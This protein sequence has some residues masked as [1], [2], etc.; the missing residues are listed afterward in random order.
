M[1]LKLDS[2]NSSIK[3][4][5]TFL[6]TLFILYPVI[7][8]FIDFNE[9]EFFIFTVGAWGCLNFVYFKQN[10][11][12]LTKTDKL[13]LCLAIY[14]VT[15]Y[16]ILGNSSVFEIL[17]WWRLSFI[18]LFFIFRGLSYKNS[19]TLKNGLILIVILR[20]VVELTI[21]TLQYFNIIDASISTHFPVSG[22]FTTPN[23]LAL[24]L[25]LGLVTLIILRTFFKKNTLVNVLIWLTFIAG[26]ILFF[27]S[28]SR[29]AY[30][31]LIAVVSILF[32]YKTNSVLKFKLLSKHLRIGLF[33]TLGFLVSITCYFLYN[34]KKDSADGRLF[35]AKITLT[36]IIKKPIFGYGSFTFEEGYNSAKSI[37]FTKQKRG[38]SEIKIADHISH[39]MNDYIEVIYEIGVLGLTLSILIFWSIFRF[40][41]YKN[42]FQLYAILIFIYLSIAALFTTL[43]VN[44]F[45]VL[46]LIACMFLYENKVLDITNDKKL[47]SAKLKNL[48]V[49]SS[50]VLLTLG[51]MKIYAFHWEKKHRDKEK[52]SE[53]NSNDWKFWTAIMAHNG[54]HELTCGIILHK[55]FNNKNEAM[56]IMEKGV[57]KN[58][59][60]NNIRILALYY[61]H[62]GKLN[63]AEKLLKFNIGNEPF[64]FEPRQDLAI[65]YQKLGKKKEYVALLNEIIELPEKVPSIKTKKIKKDAKHRLNVFLK[66]N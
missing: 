64:L 48:F 47:K 5:F 21:G 44:S 3:V 2:V 11:G 41:D 20:F 55:N 15:H 66:N 45:F 57:M 24:C 29:S 4:A 32:I 59:K 16:T 22:T 63:R 37:Y 13:L 10:I 52:Y 50:F 35:S 34:L 31:A 17:F 46:S 53:T 12:V 54:Y 14:F 61:G 36:E 26:A 28:K 49:A 33:I 39:A 42:D 23:H 30:L 25:G 60:P 27:L 38:W 9:R 18:L 65:V 58:K 7:N 56:N 6:F 40:F 51:A 43:L 62:N 8:L 1:H 19:N